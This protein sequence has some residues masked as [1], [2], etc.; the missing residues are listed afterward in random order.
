MTYRVYWTDDEGINARDFTPDKMSESLKFMN[1]LRAN[2]KNCFV[3]FVSENPNS[4]GKPGIT[5]V[6]SDYSWT[7]RR[8]NERKIPKTGTDT[9]E[10]PV[11]E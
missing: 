4:V 2:P 3:T 7:K 8:H 6:G 1:E 9:I 5:E 11:D 10:C